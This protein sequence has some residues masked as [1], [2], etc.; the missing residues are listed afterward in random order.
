MKNYHYPLSH[1]V[2]TTDQVK[3]LD[4]L[5]IESGI[6]GFTLM[7]RAGQFMFDSIR[8]SRPNAKTML[9]FCGVGNNAG[10]GYI[11]ARL[12]LEK[13]IAVQVLQL[14]EYLTGLRGDA[15]QAQLAYFSQGGENELFDSAKEYTAEII[16]DAL[17][18]TGL[19]RD[20]DGEWA[21]AIAAMNAS[22]MTAYIAAV[23]IPSG[24]NAS[25]GAIMGC[26]VVASET[27][28]FVGRKCGLFTGK[29]RDYVGKLRFYDLAIADSIT[30]SFKQTM[31]G[32]KC[33][34]LEHSI[35]L[36]KRK[37]TA[38]KGSHGHVLLI[39]G[40]VGMSGAIRMA[41]EAALTIGAGLVTVLTH[42]AHAAWLNLNRPELMVKGVESPQELLP[43]LQ[44]AN[45]IAI[46]P[47]LGADQWGRELF[48]AC[49][50]TEHD[51]IVDADGLNLLSQL[52]VSRTNWILTPHPGE[53]ARLLGV[54]V[55]AIEMDRYDAVAKIQ[56][57]YSGYCVLK[58]AGSLVADGEQTAI[59]TLGNPGMATAGMGDVLTG[60]IAG[61][62]AQGVSLQTAARLGVTLHAKAA[63]LAVAEKG[64]RGL[65]ATDLYPYLRTLIN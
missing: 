30:Q 3:E 54:T 28:T 61:L 13:G 34:L 44:R 22:A 4:C 56:R 26:A 17:F 20:V 16:V 64:E 42:P 19:S 48:N 18:G 33:F 23:D 40:T 39:G 14:G 51:K 53:A 62:R 6:S 49:L 25:T 60:I 52:S 43:Y 12:A 57:N 50:E 38:H 10:D 59:S 46:G 5:A 31:A 35:R 47:G 2:Y 9:I 24:L 45:V 27:M 21:N 32:E 7:T 37:E 36:P 65:L 15:L 58:G 8:Q 29:A 63:D 1:Q 11:I 55:H 41:A